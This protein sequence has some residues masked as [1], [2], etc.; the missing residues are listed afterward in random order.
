MNYDYSILKQMKEK[1]S[2]KFTEEND[3]PSW[4]TFQIPQP[5][6]T[7]EKNVW[8]DFLKISPSDAATAFYFRVS[9]CFIISTI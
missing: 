9:H 4:Q 1:T 6:L 2:Q 3:E 5:F 8:R 7:S